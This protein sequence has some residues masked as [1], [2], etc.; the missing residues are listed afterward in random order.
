MDIHPLLNHDAGF[1]TRQ[2][3]RR[4]GVTPYELAQHLDTGRV[5]AIGRFLIARPDVDPL[6]LRVVRMG[7]RVS[8]ITAAARRRLWVASDGRVHAAP[9]V[10]NSHFTVDAE[11]PPVRVHR[12]RHPIDGTGDLI[13]IESP[14]NMLMHI[15]RCQP[16]ERAVAVFDSAVNQGMIAL[17]ELRMLASVHGGA[18][19]RV[20]SLVSN[21]SESGLESLTRVRLGY[22]GIPC[23]EQVALHG[24]RVDLLIGERLIIQLDGRQHL[25]DPR[26]LIMDREHDRALR[27][28]GYTVLRF[29]YDDV[30]R[31]WPRVFR[32]ITALMAQ[33]AHLWP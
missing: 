25:E 2:Q 33:R 9:R 3:L 12:T 27:R 22:A 26:Q 14:V 4:L 30:M 18:L 7:G 1:G 10:L 5:I 17:E 16:L 32:E 20:V 15:A 28:L 8:C 19:A 21:L 31:D 23:R 6:Y 24:H 11:R 29:G 13:P